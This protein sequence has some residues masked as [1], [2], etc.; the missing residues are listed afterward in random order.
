MGCDTVVF[1]LV[2]YATWW[3][4]LSLGS[5]MGR[6]LSP[7]MSRGSCGFRKSLKSFLLISG[8]VSPPDYLA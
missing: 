5:Q 3:V 6:H 8:D 1:L 2:V 4:E 7:G